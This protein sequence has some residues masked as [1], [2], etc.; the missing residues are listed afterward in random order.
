MG[1][2][3][4]LVTDES[5]SNLVNSDS[6]H[7]VVGSGNH[8]NGVNAKFQSLLCQA[9][10]DGR[11]FFIQSL[12]QVG[13]DKVDMGRAVFLHLL[14]NG[15]CDDVSGGHGT[16]GRVLERERIR[17]RGW[18]FLAFGLCLFHGSVPMREPLLVKQDCT[19]APYGFGNQK[20]SFR[21]GGKCGWME[22]DEGEM[23]NAS[24]CSIGHC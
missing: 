23:V 6:T 1:H 3:N 12:I 9:S 21:V 5:S 17:I 14:V 16:L 8:R 11:E 18:L 24:T 20:R 10:S 22:L 15:P 4:A 7:H 2:H 13:R 19:D